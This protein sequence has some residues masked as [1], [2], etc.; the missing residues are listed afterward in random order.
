MFFFIQLTVFFKNAQTYNI[1][2]LIKA[3]S[4]KMGMNF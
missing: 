2:F 3:I 4:A 1:C